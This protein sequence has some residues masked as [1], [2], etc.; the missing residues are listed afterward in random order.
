MGKL[1]FYHGTSRE[2]WK[3]VKKQGSLIYPRATP[4]SP[5]ATPVVYL[6]KKRQEAEQYGDVILK[7]MYDPLKNPDKNNYHKDIWQI[8]VYEPIPIKDVKHIATYEFRLAM[9]GE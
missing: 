8:R 7:V 1:T 2:G 5:N 4:A 9:K 6:A 3:F